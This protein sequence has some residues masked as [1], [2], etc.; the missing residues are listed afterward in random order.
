MLGVR[1]LQIGPQEFFY[2]TKGFSHVSLLALIQNPDVRKAHNLLYPVKSKEAGQVELDEVENHRA[3]AR[4]RDED[5][6]E[7]EIDDDFES[8]PYFH[9]KITR[10]EAEDKL[11]GKPQGT[12]LTRFVET[13][14]SKLFL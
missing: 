11:Q 13:S 8:L 14:Y 5:E 3:E 4:G 10:N 9:G 6:E 7:A 1:T 12:F 2:I